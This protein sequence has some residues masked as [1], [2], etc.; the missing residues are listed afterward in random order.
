MRAWSIRLSAVVA[1]LL[2]ACGEPKVWYRPGRPDSVAP[3][4]H[5]RAS[6]A[7]VQIIPKWRDATPEEEDDYKSGSGIVLGYRGGD[8]YIMTAAH[9]VRTAKGGTADELTVRFKHA[10]D[11]G[12]PATIAQVHETD[13]FAVIRV[14]R[15]LEDV[16]DL[17]LVKLPLAQAAPQ[18]GQAVRTIS[19][20]GAK[21]WQEQRAR[22]ASIGGGN[23]VFER[24]AIEPGSSG[25][26]ILSDDRFLLGMIIEVQGAEAY[27]IPIER[28]LQ[29]LGEWRIP[30][31]N[32]L[33]G[34]VEAVLPRVYTAVWDGNAAPLVGEPLPRGQYDLAPLHRSKLDLYGGTAV[35]VGNPRN[36]L[37]YAELVGVFYQ[38]MN[39][40]DARDTLLHEIGNVIGPRGFGV[41]EDGNDTTFS[42][43]VVLR[44]K[45][46]IQVRVDAAY[47]YVIV[48]HN[49]TLPG[50]VLPSYLAHRLE[51]MH[52]AAR[53]GIEAGQGANP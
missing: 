2:V 39:R 53:L 51:D 6:R 35:I 43:F 34:N 41:T 28:I 17:E 14:T 48:Y 22:V 37:S 38:E 47:I 36:E 7:I 50:G 20:P 40:K 23:M 4:S 13:D 18:P 16:E 45:I 32:R 31:R 52:K 3:E 46:S 25:G 8:L 15:S 10:P 29:I 44:G 49:D 19:N 33:A 30:Y 5:E 11:V 24:G 21:L 12:V 27:G 26:A 9:V 42:K 1:C